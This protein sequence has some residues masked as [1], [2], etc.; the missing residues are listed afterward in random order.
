MSESIEQRSFGEWRSPI[1]TD[2][3][4]SQAIGL[5]G[6]VPYGDDLFWTESRP[7]EGGRTVI[8]R[9]DIDGKETDV[10]PAPFNARTRVHEYGGGAWLNLDDDIYFS[11]FADGF[12]DGIFKFSTLYFEVFGRKFTLCDPDFG[13]FGS[14]G[15]QNMVFEGYMMYFPCLK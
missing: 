10:I 2:L 5:G 12:L 4:I 14:F 8:V 6:P 13:Y 11:N 15:C 7:Q 3:I 9:R 1:T